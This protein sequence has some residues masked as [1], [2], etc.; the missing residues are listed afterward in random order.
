MIIKKKLHIQ[1]MKFTGFASE[2]EFKV[3]INDSKHDSSEH[4]V[5][6]HID[7][8]FVDVEAPDIKQEDFTVAHIE[9]LKELKKKHLA[10]SHLK[11]ESLNQQISELE[12]LD[13][14]VVS[15]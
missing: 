9:Q 10:E 1:A 3:H 11:A 6:I 5:V 2:D 12:C 15:E 14:K 7:T 4:A 8:V 13:H